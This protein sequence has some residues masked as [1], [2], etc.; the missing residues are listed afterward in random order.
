MSCSCF[1]DCYWRRAGQLLANVVSISLVQSQAF[2]GRDERR[3]PLNTPAWEA[4]FLQANQP[5]QFNF[6]FHSVTQN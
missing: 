5:I 4:T 2:V 3:A 6:L 1:W